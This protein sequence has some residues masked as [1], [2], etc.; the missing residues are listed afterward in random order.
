MAL[1]ICNSNNFSQSYLTYG[2]N[3][4]P[5]QS[6]TGSNGNKRVTIYNLVLYSEP[7]P[8]SLCM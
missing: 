4:T 7:L 1:S 5:G 6:G 2:S 8:L 3:T